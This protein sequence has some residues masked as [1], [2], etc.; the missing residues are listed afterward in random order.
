MHHRAQDIMGMPILIDVYDEGVSPRVL[1]AAFD[2]LRRVDATFS[3]Y[4]CDSEISRLNRGVISMRHCSPLVRSVLRSCE[5]LRERTGGYFDH[6]AAGRRLKLESPASADP[7]IDPS[8]YVKGWA[9]DGVAEILERGGARNYCAE[10]AGDMLLAGRP[11]ADTPWRIG[12]QH[13]R[14]AH[15]LAL[16]VETDRRCAV[17]TSATYARG[18]HI[19]D[20]F[21]SSTPRG[22]LS[23][24]VIG[25]GDL[26]TADAFATAIFAMGAAGSQWAAREAHPYAAAVVDDADVVHST[27]GFEDWQL[28]A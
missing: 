3:T 4:R 7:P 24:T 28:T 16:I 11:G 13:P 25:E 6:V 14:H 8:G 20:P 26:A 18:E 15:E 17:A 23:V 12:I 19:V 1:D 2:W 5:E 21:G 27:A 22:L 10:A 9:M